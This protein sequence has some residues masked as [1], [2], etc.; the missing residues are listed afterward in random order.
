MT[1]SG[2]NPAVPIGTP[3]PKGIPDTRLNRL[4]NWL[5]SGPRSNPNPELRG[6]RVR[7]CTVHEQYA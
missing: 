4:R 3:I 1:D 5:D 7:G 6:H 2:G